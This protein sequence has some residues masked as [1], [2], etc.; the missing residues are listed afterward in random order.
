M[1]R[2]TLLHVGRGIW[3]LVR[4]G[5]P[6]KWVA[7]ESPPTMVRNVMAQFKFEG[8]LED[9]FLRVSNKAAGPDG[10]NFPTFRPMTGAFA[11]NWKVE[12][13]STKV[14]ALDTLSARISRKEVA[15]WGSKLLIGSEFSHIPQYWE[16]L[17]DILKHFRHM[18]TST[19][20]PDAVY[21]SMFYY[22]RNT[23]YMQAFCEM[24]SSTTNT[25]LTSTGEFLISLWDLQYLS[26]LPINGSFYNEVIPSATELE[27]YDQND[28]LYL[29][30]SCK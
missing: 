27:G 29:P 10:I 30:Y 14:K 2:N 3:R 25:L 12:H 28:S 18:L 19:N 15:K 1:K 17:E 8:A 11:E 4:D 6:I 20:I 9:D 24:W 7:H 21:A 23:P 13:P 16:W 5:I 22:E 26:G